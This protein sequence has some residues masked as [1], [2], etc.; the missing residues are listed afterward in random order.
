MAEKFLL[1]T[2]I[3]SD[4][5]DAVCLAYLLANPDV[6]LLGITTVSGEAIGRAMLASVLVQAAGQD[7]PIYPGAENPLLVPQR[8]TTA[9]HT[10]V[11]SEWPHETEFP[12][13]AAVDF[14]RRTIRAH[15]YEITLL[16]IG[17]LT[18][19]ALLFHTD[20][21]TA[22]M[23]KKLVMMCGNFNT[24]AEIAEWN[25]AIDPHA[26]KMVYAT[27]VPLHQSIGLNVTARVTMPAYAVRERFAKHELLAPVLDMAE[28][29]FKQQPHITFHD[30][31]AAV[32]ALHESVC[33]LERGIVEV[34][35][36]NLRPGVTDFYATPTGMH[37]VAVDVDEQRFFEL[38]FDAFGTP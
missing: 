7:I 10:A 2:D 21:D 28:V 36:D 27:R 19:I 12:R 17:P 18:N 11:L 23:L 22:L 29:Y 9:P 33:T 8:Q 5:D 3:G 15:P 16:T 1:D 31:L 26:T 20:P 32:A 38:Y 25:A 24:S 34:K 13:G 30:P 6:D 14:L 35:L 4:I 37:D